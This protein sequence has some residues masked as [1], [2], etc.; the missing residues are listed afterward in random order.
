MKIIKT[1]I[2]DFCEEGTTVS[3][4]AKAAGVKETFHVQ[5]VG[6]IYRGDLGCRVMS[7]LSSSK[8]DP[9]NYPEFSL[10][11]VVYHAEAYLWQKE[12]TNNNLR[13]R[14]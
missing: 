1:E 12:L 11:R 6:G 3:V 13:V 9:S 10:C 14:A 5:T 4:T 7:G 2:F 8:I